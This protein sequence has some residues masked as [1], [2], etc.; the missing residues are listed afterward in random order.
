[1][2]VEDASWKEAITTRLLERGYYSLQGSCPV[3]SSVLKPSTK[4]KAPSTAA[5]ARTSFPWVASY[6]VFAL[7]ESTK[8]GDSQF[9]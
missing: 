3:K 1:M 5:S 7:N 9:P 8:L 6:P 2:L 4:N